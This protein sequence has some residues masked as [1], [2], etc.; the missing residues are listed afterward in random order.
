[1]LKSIVFKGIHGIKTMDAFLFEW[2]AY[3]D[4]YCTMYARI[5][6]D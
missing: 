3:I 2:E 4:R 1:M 6:D 5:D